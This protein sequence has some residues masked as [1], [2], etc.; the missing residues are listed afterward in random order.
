[1]GFLR[2]TTNR[3]AL[4]TCLFFVVIA[5]T[6]NLAAVRKKKDELTLAALQGA[7]GDESRKKTP[8]LAKSR[9]VDGQSADR[10][11]KKKGPNKISS[12]K[13]GAKVDAGKTQGNS[14]KPLRLWQSQ[15]QHNTSRNF[16]VQVNIHSR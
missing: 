6:S 11:T 7:A 1:V 10:A 2:G 15:A 16:L 13:M 4:E 9:N 5:E 12:S 3:A 8:E 14:L